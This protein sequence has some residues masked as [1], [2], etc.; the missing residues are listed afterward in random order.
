[1]NDGQKMPRQPCSVLPSMFLA[2]A[3][4]QN[5]QI[6][7][8][9]VFLHIEKWPI[10]D[11]P[12]KPPSNHRGLQPVV[13]RPVVEIKRK[14]HRNVLYFGACWC[15]AGKIEWHTPLNLHYSIS[16]WTFLTAMRLVA[17]GW[18]RWTQS[19]FEFPFSSCPGNLDLFSPFWLDQSLRLPFKLLPASDSKWQ[20]ARAHDQLHAKRTRKKSTPM[21]GWIV[22]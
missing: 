10:S 18:Y 3:V 14:A 9:M 21:D 7:T 6:Q 20:R 16:F 2:D 8:Q 22:I 13:G 17:C 5:Q 1:M 12:S 19:H 4:V 11:R 15:A